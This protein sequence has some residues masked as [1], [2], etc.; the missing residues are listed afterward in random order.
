MPKADHNEGDPVLESFSRNSMRRWCRRAAPP[1]SSA[2]RARPFAD[3]GRTGED[4]GLP[5]RRRKRRGAWA[6]LGVRSGSTSQPSISGNTRKG[7]VGLFPEVPSFGL[8]PPMR[9]S[10]KR[11]LTGI[12][13]LS[14][15][16]R[17]EIRR[18]DRRVCLPTGGAQG[19]YELGQD[20]AG[21]SDCPSTLTPDDVD[22]ATRKY[23]GRDDV[24]RTLRRWSHPIRSG[25]NRSVLISF[26]D[27]MV[28]EGNDPPIR[29][30]RPPAPGAEP[31]TDPSPN[32]RGGHGRPGP[33]N[34]E[35]SV[36]FI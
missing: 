12:R 36:G 24:K 11:T 21:L 29:P 26:Y 28:E 1:L 13:R 34:D 18:G 35:R 4:S 16:R 31:T 7:W 33:D 10:R 22:N 32:P 8:G 14:Y 27:W 25:K 20:R 9:M 15:S 6:Y 17:R 5:Q 3:I 23:T 19:R 2:F 30:D